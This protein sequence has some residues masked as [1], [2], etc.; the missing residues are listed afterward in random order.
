MDVPLDNGIYL[1]NSGIFNNNLGGTI[2]ITDVSDADHSLQIDANSNA[3]PATFTNAGI[4][5]ITNGVDHSLRIQEDGVF[6]N[7]AGGV[8]NIINANTKG[9]LLESGAVLKVM[10]I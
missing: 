2:N 7:S 3:I 9:I 6:T 8:L 4:L 10:N 5:T 1:T